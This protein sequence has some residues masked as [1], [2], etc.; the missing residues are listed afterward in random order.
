MLLFQQGGAGELAYNGSILFSVSPTGTGTGA[1]A[2]VCSSCLN[3]FSGSNGGTN[4][5]SI[6]AGGNCAGF[7]AGSNLTGLGEA[8]VGGGASALGNGANASLSSQSN[9]FYGSGG[10]SGNYSSTT[11]L[12]GI[13]GNGYVEIYFYS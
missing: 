9:G 5:P 6:L 7:I 3:L 4:N 1:N 8:A 12:P 13:G 10:A 2:N 11:P